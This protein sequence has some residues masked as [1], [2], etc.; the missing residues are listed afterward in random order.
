M[1]KLMLIFLLFFSAYSFGQTVPDFDLIKLE[2]ASDYKPADPF[3]LQTSNYLLSTPVKKNDIN[4]QKSLQFIIK[5]M[6][7]TPDYSFNITDAIDRIG[8][9]NTDLLGIYMAALTKYSLENKEAA[10][11]PKQVKLNAMILLLEYCENKN[12]NLKLTKQLK[13][14]AEAKEKGE[15]E[16]ALDS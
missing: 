5:W 3:A 4:R 12:N 15:L 6:S 7:G 9:G 2:K 11:D 13:K 14:L 1:K 16:Q 10:K 8:K